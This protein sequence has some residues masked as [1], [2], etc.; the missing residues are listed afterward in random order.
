ML[1]AAALTLASCSQEDVVN[2]VGG[3]TANIHLNISLPKDFSSRA[4]GSG[5]QATNLAVLVYDVTTPGSQ[6][7][8]MQGAATFNGNNTTDVDL[9]LVTNKSYKLA[10]FAASPEAMSTESTQNVY[11][12]NTADGS[13]SVD[14]SKMTSDLNLTDAY[15][16]FYG[17]YDTGKVGNATISGNVSLTRPVAQINWGTSGLNGVTG[18]NYSSVFGTD[19]AFIQ[20]T[21]K[22]QNVPN[23]LNLLAGGVTNSGTNTTVTL[24]DFAIPPTTENFPA[25]TDEVTYT[26]VAVQYL[27]AGATTSTYNLTLT[28]TNNGADSDV[29]QYTNDIVVSSVPVQANYQT[30][31]YGSLLTSNTDLTISKT[32]NFAG[33]N[34]QPL[35]WNGDITY[36]NVDSSNMSVQLNKP[37]D[38]AGLAAMVNGT[39]NQTAQ[40]FDGYTITLAADFDMNNQPFQQIGTAN[41]NGATVTGNLFKGTFD[42]KNHTISNVNITSTLSGD[43][44][45]GFIGGIAGEGTTVKDINFENVSVSA[46]NSEMVG[47]AI[48]SVSEGAI[49]DNVN[50]NSG[51]VSGKNG[52]GGVI[53]RVVGAGTVQNCSNGAEVSGG[54]NVGG[55]I[56]AAYRTLTG[57]TM[58][59]SGCTNNGN[60][61]GNSQAVAGVVG[62]SA[63]EVSG[64]SNSGTVTNSSSATGGIVGQQ[65][66]AGSI[67]GC[68][69]TGNIIGGATGGSLY[70]A[71]GIVGWIRYQ[72]SGYQVEDVIEVYGNTNYGSVSGPT[73]VGGIVGAWYRCGV[74]YGNSNFSTSLSGGQ[75]VAGIVGGSQWIGEEIN[76]G[77]FQGTGNINILYVQDNY[78]TTTQAQMGGNSSA[79][80]FVYVNTGANTIVSGNSMDNEEVVKNEFT[81]ADSSDGKNTFSAW[82]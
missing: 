61:S 66:S 79:A 40:D 75:F 62:L 68:T 23:T 20:T 11:T 4:L 77:L 71:G 44:A 76:E 70:G 51:T 34:D 19:G 72:A 82:Q 18:N 5:T 57:E 15:D 21:L 3:E 26:Y 30:N 53:G 55:V 33:T 63:A 52:V 36:P 12:I 37:S 35:V 48:G 43:V 54:D 16:C 45:V 47:G 59:V 14:Y 78:S 31:I 8:V 56:G 13:I 27:L 67:S 6:T 65:V 24:S 41:R 58:T 42:G 80:P 29:T 50:V 7:F 38:L 74:C 2:S 10:F 73:G 1:G 25:N 39:N 46:P 81:P 9:D 64:C 69:N 60:V 17:S 22:A 28:I 32:L 49:V